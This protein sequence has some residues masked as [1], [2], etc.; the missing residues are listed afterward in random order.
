ME[1]K[2]ETHGVHNTFL[3][4][5]KKINRSRVGIVQRR[6]MKKVFEKRREQNQQLSRWIVIEIIYNVQHFNK[7]LLVVDLY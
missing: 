5:K 2:I 6:E 7:Y 3:I 1:E 4:G